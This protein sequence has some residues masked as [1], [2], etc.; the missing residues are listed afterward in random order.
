MKGY[1]SVF[2]L[3]VL[4]GLQYRTAA[5]AGILTNFFWGAIS[6]MVLEA[7]YASSG[8]AQ[9]ISLEETAAYIWLR[10]SL[11][12]LVVLWLRDGEIAQ[13]IVTGQVS[14]ELT[15]P[16]TLYSYWFAK[17][18][19]YRLAAGALRFWPILLAARLLP[20]PYRLQLPPD[21]MTAVLFLWSMTLS[22]L[23]TV[24]LTMIMYATIF[25]TMTPAGSVALF[26]GISDFLA[27]GI[28]PLPLMPAWVQALAYRLPFYTTQ[29][30]P[31]RIYS[32][33]L[34]YPLAL[35]SIMAQVMWL[36]ATLVLGQFLL[37]RALGRIS[38]QGG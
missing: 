7:F 16:Y 15:R 5:G 23:I 20:A 21:T 10:Q 14:Y 31:F 25:T 34:P 32:G 19:A 12:M 29:D 13:S 22:M 17:S 27:G 8:L 4:S 28:V 26:A 3:R 33:H 1:I 38:V 9:P 30:V 37:T 6:I 36:G 18:L 11:L 35:E 24:A 2:R